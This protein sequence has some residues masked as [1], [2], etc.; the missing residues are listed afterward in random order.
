MMAA[1]RKPAAEMVMPVSDAIRN[2]A[3]EKLVAIF[4]QSEMDFFRLYPDV[5]SSRAWW[6]T[7]RVVTRE[8]ADRI[9]PSR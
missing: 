4:S 2:G 1:N 9:R 6:P 8:V 7:V 3:T 5:P